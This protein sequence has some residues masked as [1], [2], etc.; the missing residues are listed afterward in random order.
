MNNFEIMESRIEEL[1]FEYVSL[2]IEEIWKQDP[3]DYWIEVLG[4]IINLSDMY[5]DFHNFQTIV[6]YKILE[7]IV[8]EYYNWKS[9][10]F[11][12]ERIKE[13]LEKIKDFNLYHFYLFFKEKENV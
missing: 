13:N 11:M 5:I 7:N 8:Y 6:K 3:E 9:M 4:S 10:S 12:S 1:Y 2:V